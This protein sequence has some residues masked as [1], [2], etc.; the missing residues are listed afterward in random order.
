MSMKED[1]ARLD[2]VM[3]K[4]GFMKL[5]QQ[6]ITCLTMVKVSPRSV[7]NEC[8]GAVENQMNVPGL[9]ILSKRKLLQPKMVYF[10]PNVKQLLPRGYLMT[11]VPVFNFLRC[12]LQRYCSTTYSRSG[13]HKMWILKKKTLKSFYMFWKDLSKINNIKRMIFPHFIQ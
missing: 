7:F 10:R 11:E 8:L 5:P 1:I 9:L 4:T 13:F 3:E 6:C 2:C 12:K